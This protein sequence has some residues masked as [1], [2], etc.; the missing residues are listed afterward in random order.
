MF[1]SFA[2]VDHLGNLNCYEVWTRIKNDTA[3]P[4]TS[5][6]HKVFR[7]HILLH[8][9]KRPLIERPRYTSLL[10]VSELVNKSQ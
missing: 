6:Y 10:V 4:I 3:L 5:N 9:L 1:H 7:T 8:L 2:L